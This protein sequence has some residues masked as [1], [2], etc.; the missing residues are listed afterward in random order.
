MNEI[1]QKLTYLTLD[2]YPYFKKLDKQPNAFS[3]SDYREYYRK[4]CTPKYYQENLK[5]KL[6]EF[7]ENSFIANFLG[8]QESIV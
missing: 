3:L 2:R 8:D 5:T 7:M 1:N 4:C 6:S